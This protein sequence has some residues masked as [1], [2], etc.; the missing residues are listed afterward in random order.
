MG[1]RLNP[2][3]LGWEIWKRTAYFITRYELS[4]YFLDRDS[5]FGFRVPSPVPQ[6][7]AVADG[8]FAIAPLQKGRA[9]NCLSEAAL[10]TFSSAS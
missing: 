1:S 6:N 10:V 9:K 2:T 8:F 5:G 4:S 7:V 3:L